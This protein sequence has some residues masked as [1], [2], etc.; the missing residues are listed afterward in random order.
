MPATKRPKPLYQRG[1]YALYGR[2][3]RNLEIVWYDRERRRERS[4]SAG[5]RDVAEARIAVDRRFLTSE[6]VRHCS[7]CGRP[8]DGAENPLVLDVI[9]DYL[10]LSEGKA[11]I[12]SAR[13]R[14]GHVVRY[15]EETENSTAVAAVDDTW[16]E[17]FRKWMGSQPISGGSRGAA[18]RM[19]SPSSIE[20]CLLALRAAINA[21][22]GVTAR[23]KPAQQADVAESPVYRADVETIAAMFNYCLRPDDA[24]VRH[25]KSPDVTNEKLVALRREER[26]HLLAYLRAAV[27]T[28]ARPDAIYAL[29]RPQWVKAAQALRLNPLGRKQTKKYRPPI[30]IPHQFA[31]HLN[32]MGETWLPVGSIRAAWDRMCT[33]LGLPKDGEAG[34]KLIRRSIA[35]I[36]RARMGEANWQQGRIMLG[37]VK[38]NTS[39]IYALRDPANLGVALAT[40]ERI[41]EDIEK[42]AEGAFYRDFTAKHADKSTA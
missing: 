15:L 42:H 34:E 39:D 21:S 17:A 3:G 30:P 11:G 20:G 13:T 36:A 16:A 27:A 5:T 25:W 8:W 41:I 38:S 40:T 9:A 31:P 1:S 6:G 4:S 19:R 12:K 18:E 37:H 23:F 35:T 29:R 28:W 33:S 32:A 26:K 2:P 14:L 10:I 7:T 22:P 24:S